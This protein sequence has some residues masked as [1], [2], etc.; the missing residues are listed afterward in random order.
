VRIIGVDLVA[1][2]GLAEASLQTILSEIGTDMTR[3]PSS[4]H[5]CSWLGLAPHNDISGGKVLR[6]RTGKVVSR[7]NQ[8]FRQA[9]QAVARSDSTFGAYYRSMRARLGPQQAIVATAHKIARV[10]YHMLKYREAFQP[11]QLEVYEQRR[12]ERELKH[13]QRRANRLGYTL[14]MVPGQAPDP[15]T[16]PSDAIVA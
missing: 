7:A 15:T 9:A 14:T 4:K 13:L 16:T 1:V 6:S 8:A 11:E 5:F 12:R 10:F 2:T 3:F